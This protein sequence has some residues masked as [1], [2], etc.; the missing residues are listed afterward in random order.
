MIIKVQNIQ[1]NTADGVVT[2][3]HWTALVT[4][5]HI[6]E[7][8]TNSEGLE[9]AEK[10]IIDFQASSYGSVGFSRNEDS[11]ELIPFADL[12]EDD[13]VVWVTA[14]L[15]EGLEAGLLAQI[16]E[17]KNPSSTMGVPWS[18]SIEEPVEAPIEQVV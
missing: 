9:I 15:P 3:A 6:E 1:S 2:T 10:E 11:P 8:Y 18:S 13:V 5:S 17:K 7:A 14:A 12:T 16:E 4:E